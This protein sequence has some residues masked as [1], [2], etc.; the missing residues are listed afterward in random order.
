MKKFLYLLLATAM[1]A[2]F[3]CTGDT[4]TNSV[5]SPN[6]NTLMPTGTVQGI[7]KDACTNEPIVGAIIDIGVAKATTNERGQY[8]MK[9]VPATSY[10]SPG[11][12]TGDN[13]IGL[14]GYSGEYSA[15][16]DMRSA[17][18][19]VT[20]KNNYPQFSYDEVA[21]KFSSLEESSTI[22]LGTTNDT[23]HNTPV[24]GLGNGDYDFFVGQLTTSISGIAVTKNLKPVPNGYTV[25]LYSLGSHWNGNSATGAEGH[26]IA[27]TLTK[28]INNIEGRFEFT[29]LEAA[30]W[31]V[32]EV[33]DTDTDVPTKV[34][35]ET[36]R[37][38]C[39]GTTWF[40]VQDG[41]PVIVGSTDVMCP[42][43]TAK[44][45][46][47][48]EDMDPAVAGGINVTF[49]F[50]EPIKATVHN[51]GK[52]LTASDLGGLYQDIYVNYEG[53]KADFKAGNIAHTI[54]WD[55]TMT[56]LTV[57][58]PVVGKASVYS[59]SLGSG[60][61]AKLTDAVG[62]ELSKGP[63]TNTNDSCDPLDIF[64]DQHKVAGLSG[65]D[66]VAQIHFTT[67]GSAAAGT[68][69]LQLVNTP[70]DYDAPIDFSWTETAGAK[71]YNLYCAVNQVWGATVNTHPS[72]KVNTTPIYSTT[73]S[74]DP[75]ANY[76]FVENLAIK[77][78][79]TC[80]VVGVDAD[81]LEGPASNTV[82]AS[83]TVAPSI[84]SSTLE[85]NIQWNAIPANLPKR[86][87]FAVTFSE[88][89]IK[90]EIQNVAN[91]TLNPLAF[92][93]T[94][95][96]VTSVVY[97]EF[98]F[99]ATVTLSGPLVGIQSGSISTGPNGICETVA[100]VNDAQVIQLGNGAPNTACVTS[101]GAHVVATAA[102]AGDNQVIAVGENAL[103]G[104]VI[105]DSGGN[106][107]CE[108]VAGANETQTILQ[109]VVLTAVPGAP[110]G[111]GLANQVAITAGIGFVL[112]AT[113]AGDDTIANAPIFVVVS[114]V[115][116]VATNALRATADAIRTD[117]T[118]E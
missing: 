17:K 8:V 90:S 14:S 107:I 16:I 100:G 6:P 33:I 101:S 105:I 34:G 75:N 78:T 72:V 29:A 87:F 5:G 45:P 36:K 2:T 10:V 35:Y 22:N 58:I 93:G 89:M 19:G 102:A 79:H 77:L 48:W 32:V 108:T 69:V 94:V 86:D 27:K 95:P 37:T 117:G 55:S 7:L 24:V 15:T 13:G 49:T 114:G 92:T 63:I 46:T 28:T 60:A 47:N 104:Q 85:E 106:G 21:V 26:L 64:Q 12:I 56:V 111:N 1:L 52:G 3:G 43:I 113:P 31:Y 38:K 118:I 62:N 98:T 88:P 51:T 54:S 115:H 68:P 103:S 39:E 70:Y 82:T 73:Y 20:G 9:K 30:Q 81:G 96:T 41:D 23:N 57:N 40:G 67:Y 71:Y 25:K 4:N 53:N 112:Q 44:T 65:L 59:V 74:Y 116:D 99:T 61:V 18:N 76:T 50:S 110:L 109:G 83:D 84:V 11:I 91:W 42:F 80:F 97:N 66:L